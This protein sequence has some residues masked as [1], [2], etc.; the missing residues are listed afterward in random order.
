MLLSK[1]ILNNIELESHFVNQPDVVNITTCHYQRVLERGLGVSLSAL[2]RV[3][4]SYLLT[5]PHR[6]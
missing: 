5:L 1:V 3:K 6:P 4:S 2:H